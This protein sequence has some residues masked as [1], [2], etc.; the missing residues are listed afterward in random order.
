MRLLSIG[1]QNIQWG[2]ENKLNS[3]IILMMTCTK[4]FVRMMFIVFKSPGFLKIKLVTALSQWSRVT[5][6][7]QEKG[8]IL[9]DRHPRKYSAIMAILVK[10]AQM[11][12]V[13]I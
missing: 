11:A 7:L 2:I 9:Y 10:I 3:L 13:A 8:V 6:A 12:I 1:S 5:N 4:R